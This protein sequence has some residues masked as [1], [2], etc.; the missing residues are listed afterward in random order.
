MEINVLFGNLFDLEK[1]VKEI[2]WFCCEKH[3][4]NIDFAVNLK[5]IL[6]KLKNKTYQ[7]IILGSKPEG[8]RYHAAQILRQVRK[9]PEYK[10]LPAVFVTIF[11]KENPYPD[12]FPEAFKNLLII[13]K[14]ELQNK[15]RIIHIL[16]KHLL[17]FNN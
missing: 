12:N 8:A 1:G 7:G 9:L 3:T 14:E 10:N 15:E 4:I 2:N 5:D 11:P 13:P 17:S 6:T 16:H